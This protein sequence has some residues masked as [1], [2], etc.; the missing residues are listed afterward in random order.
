MEREDWKLIYTDKVASIF[1]RNVPEN[2]D[3]IKKYP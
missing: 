3:L 1:L 2:F